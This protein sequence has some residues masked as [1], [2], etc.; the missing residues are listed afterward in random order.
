MESGADGGIDHRIAHL[1]HQPAEQVGVHSHV[2]YRYLIA[3]E[4]FEV[5]GEC[6]L[7]ASESSTAAVTFTHTRP[8]RV[9]SNFWYA[10]ATSRS[11]LSRLFCNSTPMNPRT[12][13]EVCSRRCCASAA[14]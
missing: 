6:R 9:S 5:R 4:R 10:A 3:E 12:G 11:R 7:C 13:S 14:A 2:Q 8:A 1:N